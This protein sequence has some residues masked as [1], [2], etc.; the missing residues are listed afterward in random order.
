MDENNTENQIE[1]ST[2]S[3]EE[4]IDTQ[5]IIKKVRKS[6]KIKTKRKNRK[7]LRKLFRFFM[8]IFLLFLLIC[9]S[10]MPQWYLPKDAYTTA[11]NGTILIL[12]NKIVKPHRV[13]AFLKLHEVPEVPIYLMKTDDIERDIKKLAPIKDVYI[14]RYAFPARLQII[15]K[16]RMPVISIAQDEK[17]PLTGAYAED[18]TFIGHDFMPLSPDLKTVKVLSTD[19]NISKWNI[20]KI[21]EIQQIAASV[22]FYSGE[23]VEYIDLRNPND[24]FVKIT[25]FNIRIGKI[26][27]KVYDRIKRL[28]SILPKIKSQ[29]SKIKYVDV[30]WEKVNYLKLK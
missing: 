15:I 26:D 10:K 18:G 14:R 2:D 29:Q 28:S 3:E 23:K 20:E 24:V 22:E 12:N 17:S 7:V 4:V 30:G 1:V 6:R 8:T 19:K 16:E 21:R 27:S 25:E 9:F 13:L 11:H 5:Q